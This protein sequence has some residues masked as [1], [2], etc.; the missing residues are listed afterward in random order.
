MTT[1]RGT[2]SS[3]P[4]RDAHARRGFN[5]VELLIA[6]AI[7]A[8]LLTA[9]MAA[10]NASF[11]AYQSTTEVASTHTIARLSLHRILALIRN[12]TE[13]GPLPADPRQRIRESTFLD[14]RMPSTEAYPQGQVISLEWDEVTEALYVVVDGESYPL[15]EGVTQTDPDTGDTIAPFTL[16]YELGYQLYRATIDLTIVPDDDMSVELDGDNQ[17]VLH[18]VAS[19]MPRGTAYD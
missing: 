14:I 2:L 11:M 6:L 7:S 12:G 17:Q 16:E 18:L 1:R 4:R 15:L 5:L 9:T 10:L 8:A 13:F 19:A 3:R